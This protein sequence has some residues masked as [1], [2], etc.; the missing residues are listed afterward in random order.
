M[1]LSTDLGHHVFRHDTPWIISGN[2]QIPQLT[3]IQKAAVVPWDIKRLKSFLLILQ[4]A[5]ATEQQVAG[6]SYP[7]DPIDYVKLF[8]ERIAYL[9]R[10]EDRTNRI[11]R[12]GG[13]LYHEFGENAPAGKGGR[14]YWEAVATKAFK[15]TE[16]M[17]ALLGPLKT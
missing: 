13:A 10:E 1:G 11:A 8:E 9:E 17:T 5:Q 14:D 15:E 7:A 16:E 4:K 6:V 3:P 2:S 12:L